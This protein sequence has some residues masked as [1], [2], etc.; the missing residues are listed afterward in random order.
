MDKSD[1]TLDQVR[2]GIAAVVDRIRKVLDRF[3]H[4]GVMTGS[5]V[6]VRL[7]P[8]PVRGKRAS[9]HGR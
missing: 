8:T 7:S 9:R 6:P 1:S 5:V 2:D 4:S 3:Y